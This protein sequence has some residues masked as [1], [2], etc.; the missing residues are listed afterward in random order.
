MESKQ[1]SQLYSQLSSTPSPLPPLPSPTS[2][3][4]T[5]PPIQGI[6]IGTTHATN[7]ILQAKELYRVGVIRIAGHKPDSLPACAFWPPSLKQAAFAGCITI[8]G[9]FECDGR[10]ITP[11][12]PDQAKKAAETLLSMGAESIAIVGVFSP[13]ISLQ[14]EECKTSIQQVLT[15]AFPITLSSQIGGIGFIE[16]ENGT[17]LNSALKKPISQGFLQ[18]EQLK[19]TF[20]LTCPLWI[21]QNDGSIISIEQAIEYPLLTLSSG[22]TNS[23]M[24]AAKL[25]NVTDAIIVDIGGTSTDIG[26][27]QNGYPKRSLNN[28]HIGGIDLNFRMPDVLSLPIGGGTYVE[29]NHT[30]STQSCGKALREIAQ[31]FGGKSLTLTDVAYQSGHF[32]FLA[33]SCPSI[34]KKDAVKVIQNTQQ[35]IQEGDQPYAR[36]PP[37]PTRHH[38]GRG[39]VSPP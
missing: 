4:P 5:P 27:I 29:K 17:V 20:N 1:P 9:G 11:F 25:S 31:I 39:C 35:I 26:M 10:P 8:D 12:N 30:L 33:S 21:T 28:V 38:R 6:Y 32:P 15:P 22:P 18:L 3:N 36:Q 14:E 23:F 16:R 19:K 34:S 13:I 2:S 37:R 24:G 7:A